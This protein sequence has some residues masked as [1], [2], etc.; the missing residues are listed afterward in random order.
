MRSAGSSV[1]WI[2]RGLVGFIALTGGL[3]LL[4]PREPIDLEH[5]FNPA[6]LGP[7][8][9]QYLTTQE[10]RFS[11]IT[12]GVAK[13]IHWAGDKDVRTPLSVIYLHG[14]SATSEELRPVPDQI[15]AA[16][17]ANLFYTRLRGHGRGADALAQASMGDW[18]GD[19]AEAIT[20]GQRIGD[21][22]LVIATSTGGTL[23]ALAALDPKLSESLLGVVLVSPNF[24]LKARGAAL[25]DMP[26]VRYWGPLLAGRQ[27]SFP[28]RN[29]RH[30]AY[31]TTSYPTV[32]LLPMS[33]LARHARAQDYSTARVPALILISD[34]DK[35]VRP[36]LTQQIAAQWGA[37]ARLIKMDLGPGDDPNHHILAGDIMSPGQND[38]MVQSVL[39]WLYTLP[40]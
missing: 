15:A 29:P 10:A 18:M 23:A 3:Y 24:N 39:D 37:G 12:P 25:L 32:A 11:D 26:L 13:R 40:R 36:E 5:D 9:H 16:M 33:A 22:V 28:P 30:A 2:I 1:R 35:V 20:I 21:R 19:L 38:V 4:G 31:W 8:L 17:G 7:D 14:F 6:A 34:T 27:H